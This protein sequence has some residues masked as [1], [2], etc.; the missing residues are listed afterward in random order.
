[1]SQRKKRG[2][3]YKFFE[4]YGFII[5]ATVVTFTLVLLT[6]ILGKYGDSI[7]PVLH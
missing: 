7:E 4:K 5:A 2:K 3:W 6:S 1:M